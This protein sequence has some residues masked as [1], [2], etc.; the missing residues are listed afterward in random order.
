MRWARTPGGFSNPHGH[1]RAPRVLTDALASGTGAG[2][3]PPP[4]QSAAPTAVLGDLTEGTDVPVVVTPGEGTVSVAR[5]RQ[6]ADTLARRA[7]ETGLDV[8]SL[9]TD[10]DGVLD[11]HFLTFHCDCEDAEG[12]KPC[13]DDESH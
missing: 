13:D 12:N 7:A 1:A 3:C 2:G 11:V 5:N 4:G 6:R 10:S 8:P 9:V